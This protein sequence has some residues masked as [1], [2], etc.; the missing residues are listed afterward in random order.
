MSDDLE[1]L[2][3]ALRDLP[4]AEPRP[5]FVD[6]S[7]AKATEAAASPK[8][9]ALLPAIVRWETWVGVACGAA[10][11]ATLTW[12]ILRPAVSPPP[13]HGITLAVNETRNIDVLI[14]SERA[15]EDATIRIVVSGGVALDGFDGDREI[16]WH[17][18]LERGSNL[19]SLPVIAQRA[20]TA[21]LVAIIEH[22]GKTR[23]IE[24][25]LN[26]T[27]TTGARS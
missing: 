5:G 7:L 16:D 13:D 1:I 12:F 21:R 11:A 23:S 14:D 26:V 15:L 8:S 9:R 17:A 20:G 2:S 27:D 6:R 18:S 10:V 22:G 25:S 4:T 19:L 3:K 24:V